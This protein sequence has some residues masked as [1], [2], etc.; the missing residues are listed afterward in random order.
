MKK[1]SHP[2]TRQEWSR[3][4]EVARVEQSKPENANH[5]IL[6]NT[7]DRTVTRDGIVIDKWNI[8]SD[9]ATHLEN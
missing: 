4:R 1:D 9:S 5:V 2:E 7:R 8:R 3:I 6:L